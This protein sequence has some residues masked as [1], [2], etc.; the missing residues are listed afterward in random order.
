MK[1]NQIQQGDVTLERVESIPSKAKPKAATKR[2]YVLAEGEHT[3]HA[4]C[5]EK[6]SKAE[7]Y[8]VDGV[9]YVKAKEPVE[10]THEEHKTITVPKGNWKIGIVREFDHFAQMERQVKD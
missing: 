9:L 5:I 4:H 2:G 7:F 1:Q 10:L 3:G 6:T 8:E